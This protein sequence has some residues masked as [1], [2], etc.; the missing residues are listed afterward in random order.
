MIAF[1]QGYVMVRDS[2]GIVLDVKGVGYG[3]HLTD[4]ALALADPRDA[5]IRGYWIHTYINQ[6]VLKLYGFSTYE[7]RLVFTLLLALPTVGPKLALAILSTLSPQ[8]LRRAAQ[9]KDQLSL[10]SVPGIGKKKAE[11]LILELASRLDQLPIVFDEEV[12]QTMQSPQP[13]KKPQPSA[14]EPS[15]TKDSSAIQITQLQL[16]SSS[17]SSSS[18]AGASHA[19]SALLSDLR[20]AL[21]NL[22]FT[23]EEIAFALQRVLPQVHEESAGFEELFKASLSVIRHSPS[24]RSSARSFSELPT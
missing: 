2:Q 24:P 15:A 23:Q 13:Q 22:G 11:K 4:A 7:E 6:D 16:S 18:A 5:H 1:L 3:L 14:T 17:P 10:Q 20:S 9:T 19:S 21:K 12:V 8:E